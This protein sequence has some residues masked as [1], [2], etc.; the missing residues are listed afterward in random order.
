VGELVARYLYGGG[1]VDGLLALLGGLLLRKD[2]DF[3]AIQVVEAAFVQH[4]SAHPMAGYHGRNARTDCG[5][6]L[7][8]RSYR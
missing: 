8:G 7:P 2:R 1:D 3:H 4:S 6:A 5:H